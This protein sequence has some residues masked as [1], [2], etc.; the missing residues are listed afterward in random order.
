LRHSEQ[1]LQVEDVVTAGRLRLRIA[2]GKT[3]RAGHGAEIGPSRGRRTLP[4]VRC[5]PFEDWQV[6]AKRKAGPLFRRVSAGECFGNTALHPDSVRRILDHRV[7]LA[8]LTLDRFERPSADG[9]RV[10]FIIEA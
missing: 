6:V 5:G 9:L 7:R 3:D 4:P 2:R 10:G 1:A 8:G